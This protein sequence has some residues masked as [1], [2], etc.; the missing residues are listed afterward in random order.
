MKPLKELIDTRPQSVLLGKSRSISRSTTKHEFLVGKESKIESKIHKPG[1]IP[2]YISAVKNER[3]THKKTEAKGFEKCNQTEGDSEKVSNFE[4]DLLLSEQRFN[5]LKIELEKLS[6]ENKTL[7]ENKK[8]CIQDLEAQIAEIKKENNRNSSAMKKL[9]E[10][11][12]KEQNSNMKLRE[13]LKSYEVEDATKIVYLDAAKKMSD[14]KLNKEQQKL[15]DS[16]SSLQERC[17]ELENR[18]LTL[19]NDLDTKV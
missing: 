14:K 12:T 15:M 4:K 1:F 19:K 5:E 16:L 13:K 8:Y 10:S 18:E 7:K 2:R 9:A 11:L 17:K 6:E 3:E